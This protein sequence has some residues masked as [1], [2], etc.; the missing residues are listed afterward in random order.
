MA[1]IA[2][3]AR[4]G[5]ALKTGVFQAHFILLTGT[6]DIHRLT[7]PNHLVTPT[8]DQL[9]VFGAHKFNRF[10]AL[11]LA[12]LVDNLG[13]GTELRRLACLADVQ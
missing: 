8:V 5:M 4:V 13:I 9:H 10:Y 2:E 7:V 12:Q 1:R 3:L 11:F 6:A